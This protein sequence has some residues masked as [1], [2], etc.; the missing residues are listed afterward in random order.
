MPPVVWKWEAE[1]F[2]A[3]FFSSR[4]SA[5]CRFRSACVPCGFPNFR[6]CQRRFP[7]KSPVARG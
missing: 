4:Q 1:S 7:C 5:T 6:L 2:L 3:R